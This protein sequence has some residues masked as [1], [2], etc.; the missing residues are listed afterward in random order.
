M[1]GRYV[2]T[3]VA[4]VLLY[5]V[6][7]SKSHPIMTSY[8]SFRIIINPDQQGIKAQPKHLNSNRDTISRKACKRMWT[9]NYK[10]VTPA[11]TVN[12]D[13]KKLID[14]LDHWNNLNNFGWSSVGISW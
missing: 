5:T 6:L 8:I 9:D 12:A 1:S 13:Y 11:S 2:H 10:T 3:I 14:G 4:K 7:K